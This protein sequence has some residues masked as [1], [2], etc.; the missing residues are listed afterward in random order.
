MKKGFCLGLVVMLM[1]VS[2]G[3]CFGEEDI[4]TLQSKVAELTKEKEEVLSKYQVMMEKRLKETEAK[5]ELTTKFTKEQEKTKALESDLAIRSTTIDELKK[6]LSD[7]GVQLADY[8]KDKQLI[9]QLKTSLEKEGSQTKELEAKID[10]LKKKLSDLGVQ[11]ADYEKDKE[12]ISQLKTSLEKEGSQTKELEAELS[13]KVKLLD[14]RQATIEA[15]KQKEAEISELKESLAEQKIKEEGL[16][17]DLKKKM[18]ENEV[19]LSEY[20]TKTAKAEGI[21]KEL[22]EEKRFANEKKASEADYELK[23]AEKLLAYATNLYQTKET[24]AFAVSELNRYVDC[25]PGGKDADKALFMTIEAYDELKNPAFFLAA[26]LNLLY[27]YPESQFVAKAKEKIEKLAKQK[28]YKDC[29]SEIRAISVDGAEPREKRFFDYLSYLNKMTNP[30]LCDYILSQAEAFL[31]QYS[32][33]KF[34]PSAATIIGDSLVKANKDYEAISSYFKVIYL[35]PDSSS[36]AEVYFKVGLVYQEQLK[37]YTRAIDVYQEGIKKFPEHPLCSQ[38]FFVVASL[39]QEELKAYPEALVTYQ[40]VVDEYPQAQNAPLSLEEKAKLW[41][42]LKNYQEAISAF[43]Q[44][45][46]KY[47][48]SEKAPF[49]LNSMGEYYEEIKDCRSAI[50]AYRKLAREY[51][52]CQFSCGKLFLA[53]KLAKDELKDTNMAIEVYKE[54][55]NQFPGTKE[56][57]SAQKAISELKK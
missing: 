26:Y 41:V 34:A 53:G 47:A 8:E 18:E 19:A 50:S 55:V 44:L 32:E 14:Q 39:Y 1:G 16:L 33:S 4:A 23:E 11:L 24:L 35:Y 37:K 54:V 40:R 27:L 43:N 48:K 30:K 6:K 25:Y 45:V 22:E 17:A 36:L 10:E 31:T 38:Y 29:L 28:E 13:A 51:P 49:A 3:V 52:G 2:A 12:L 20:E 56:A 5:E 46:T 7:L 21:R 15:Y 57:E 42:K 9:S